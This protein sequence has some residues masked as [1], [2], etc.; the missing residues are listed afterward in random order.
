MSLASVYP[1]E[2]PAH[3][4]APRSTNGMV[5]SIHRYGVELGIGMWAFISPPVDRLEPATTHLGV[6]SHRL[7]SADDVRALDEIAFRLRAAVHNMSDCI[8]VQQC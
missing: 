5:L 3:S 8:R 1:A 6:R 2:R 4:A 7:V